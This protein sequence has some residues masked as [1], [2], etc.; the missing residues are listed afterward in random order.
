MKHC[1]NAWWKER[2]KLWIKTWVWW[3]LQMSPQPLNK[4]P[5]VGSW[6]LS[7]PAWGFSR[8]ASGLQADTKSHTYFPV[9]LPLETQTLYCPIVSLRSQ[10]SDPAKDWQQ[11]GWSSGQWGRCRHQRWPQRGQ[12]SGSPALQ[13]DALPS[14]PP[15][16]PMV[17]KL[18]FNKD[19]HRNCKSWDREKARCYDLEKRAIEVLRGRWIKPRQ[20]TLCFSHQNPSFCGYAQFSWENLGLQLVTCSSVI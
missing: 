19:C 20:K 2:W 14:E 6:P 13:A 8:E 17:C 12:P 15:G 18:C 5:A 9:A 3:Q 4:T 7:F 16:K 11:F 1:Q 10:Q